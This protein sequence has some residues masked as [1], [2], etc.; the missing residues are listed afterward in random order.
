MHVMNCFPKC[1]KRIYLEG[2]CQYTTHGRSHF[3]ADIVQ[4]VLCGIKTPEMLGSSHHSRHQIQR[5]AENQGNQKRSYSHNFGIE[6]SIAKLRTNTN[7]HYESVYL[8]SY[9]VHL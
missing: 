2:L 1:L 8:W 7:I 6:V 5:S 4:W 9:F 3:H